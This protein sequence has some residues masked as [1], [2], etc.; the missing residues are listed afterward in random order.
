MN[1]STNTNADAWNLE[2]FV[3]AQSGVY[4]Q[5]LS[6]LTAGQKRSHWMWFV[7]PQV[8]GLGASA[9]AKRYAIGSRAE[10][11]AYLAHGLLGPRLAAT[12]GAVIAHRDRSLEQIFGYPDDLKFRSSMTLFAAVAG[13]GSLFAEALDTCCAGEQDTATLAQLERI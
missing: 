9:M 8:Q 3:V 11:E 2:R 12:T 5:A 7:F 4:R 1:A 13:P 10:A 6:E